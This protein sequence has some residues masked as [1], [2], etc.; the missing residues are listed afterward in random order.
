VKN[1]NREKKIDFDFNFE[2]II[3][4]CHKKLPLPL[5]LLSLQPKSIFAHK[6][7]SF[8]ISLF[9]CHA[10]SFHSMIFIYIYLP[11]A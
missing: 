1:F 4:I 10:T 9:L 7:P 3:I 11:Q 5:F 6:K 8:P 2:E